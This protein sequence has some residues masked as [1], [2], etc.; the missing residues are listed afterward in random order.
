MI[1]LKQVEAIM[2]NIPEP[3]KGHE[4]EIIGWGGKQVKPFMGVAFSY[5][6]WYPTT[7]YLVSKHKKSYYL[8]AVPK[9]KTTTTMEDLFPIGVNVCY[10]IRKNGQNRLI[11]ASGGGAIYTTHSTYYLNSPKSLEGL[12]YA[13][14]PLTSYE[15]ATPFT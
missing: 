2:P 5:G 12:R 13:H 8:K 15:N 9:P 1:T 10:I 11:I 14:H 7:T 3:P 6:I 4:W